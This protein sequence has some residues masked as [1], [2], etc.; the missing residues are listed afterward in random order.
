MLNQLK[1]NQMLMLTTLINQMRFSRN[2]VKQMA[3]ALDE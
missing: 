2:L 3:E 1:E